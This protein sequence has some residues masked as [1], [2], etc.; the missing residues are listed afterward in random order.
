[1][2][3]TNK[4]IGLLALLFLMGTS[5]FAQKGVWVP[6]GGDIEGF[7]ITTGTYKNSLYVCGVDYKSPMPKTYIK[8][9]NGVFWSTLIEIPGYNNSISSMKEFNGELYIGGQFIEFAGVKNANSLVKWNGSNWSA[10]GA[11][12]D[13]S[14]G[15]QVRSMEVFNNK[16][17]IAGRF[18][19]IAGVQVK[20]IAVWN[21][22]ALILPVLFASQVPECTLLF[23]ASRPLTVIFTLEEVLRRLILKTVKILPALM[24]PMFMP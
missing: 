20:N 11:G 8:K 9:F 1:M 4:S 14:F 2:K 19:S 24:G 7:Q 22:S 21:G 5:L 10:V 15:P 6:A 23:K 16:L 3:K 17:Y 12:F 18:D 13:K